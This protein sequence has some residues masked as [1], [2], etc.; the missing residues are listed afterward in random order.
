[1]LARGHKAATAAGQAQPVSSVRR[2]C[3]CAQDDTEPQRRWSKPYQGFSI[4]ALPV[5]LEA[6]VEFT[7][8]ERYFKPL[9]PQAQPAVLCNNGDDA[10]VWRSPKGMA[11]VFSLDTACS[12]VHFPADAAANLIAYR[13]LMCALSDLAAMGAQPSHVSLGLTLA[14]GCTEDWVAGFAQGLAQGLAQHQI[15]LI[16]GDTTMSRQPG[17]GAVISFGVHGWVAEQ[18]FR[19]DAAQAGDLIVLTGPTGLANAAL[20]W[21]AQP[22]SSPA[23]QEASPAQPETSPAIQALLDAYWRPKPQFALAQQLLPYARAAIDVSDG[24]LADLD[25][26]AKASGLGYQLQAEALP[27]QPLLAAG[28]DQQQALQAALT[29]GDDYQLLLALAPEHW[30][31][32]AHLKLICLGQFTAKPQRDCY[33]GQ[34]L[35]TLARRGYQHHAD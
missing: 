19:R 1:M 13:S 4:P 20:P 28:L 8:I 9:R 6:D 26:M 25:H 31:K 21:L 7:W 35:L 11:E 10:A 2:S 15:G 12:G 34:Q 27:L 30:P 32:L 14:S 23:Q 33:Y 24:L 3:D 17:L 29:G 18:Y 22:E 16:G 5:A